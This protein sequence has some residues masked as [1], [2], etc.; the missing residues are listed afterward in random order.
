MYKFTGKNCY[1]SCDS[2]LCSARSPSGKSPHDALTMA[3][4]RG[5]KIDQGRDHAICPGCLKRLEEVE[6]PL[7]LV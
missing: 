5:W 7:Q 6:Q 1:L 2:S 4:R 3:V